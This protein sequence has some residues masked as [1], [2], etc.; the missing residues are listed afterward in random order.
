MAAAAPPSAALPASAWLRWSGTALA[1]TAWLS[2][3]LFGAYIVFFHVGAAA[4]GRPAEWNSV[5]PGL[6]A[7]EARLATA[8]IAA[9][10]VAGA[11]LLLLGPIQL[12]GAVRRAAPAFHRWTGR[13]YVASAL[14]A[15]LGGLAF[16]LAK[17]TIGGPVMD[18]GF[19]L[20]GALVVAAAIETYR[21][22]RARRLER[23]RA[24]AIRLF[25]LAIGSWLYRM[26]YGLWFAIGDSAG[27]ASD[28]RGPFDL[29][30]DFAFYLP[31]LAVAELFI[32]ARAAPARRTLQTA[33]AGL[34]AA[35]AA[36]LALATWEFARLAWL[37]GIAHRL[38]G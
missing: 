37:P 3:A 26:A 28:F 8:G 22:A 23:H 5:L 17:G 24:W 15:G 35:A 18:I 25:A 38:G 6:F 12:I 27:H 11:I 31:N 32:R 2:A 20:Y 29:V 21:H 14:V 9:H 13:L 30:M 4:L 10:F 19:G 16:I 34:L 1:A 7:A 33:S 36:L